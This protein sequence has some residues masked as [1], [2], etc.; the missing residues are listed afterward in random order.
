MNR[1]FYVMGAGAGLATTLLA[2]LATP[3]LAQRGDDGEF[4]ILQARYGTDRNNIDVTERLRDIARRDRRV[5]LTNELFGMDPAPGRDKMLRIYV[6]DRQGRERRFDYPENAWI[7]G[8]QFVGWSAGSW[9]EPNY[10]G[11]WHGNPYRDGGDEGQ[12]VILRAVYGNPGHDVDVTDRLRELARRDARF[13]MGNDT[14]GV[15][16]DPGR[17]KRL[18]IVTRDARGMERSFEYVEGSTV[19]GAQF[20]G[21][22]RGDWGR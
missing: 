13:R 1:R 3:A 9:G 22:G 17:T 11:G 4:V 15:D 5:K 20:T 19:D 12:Y 16:P 6:R 18:R 2:G 14:F 8:M 10:Q 7:D 21:W